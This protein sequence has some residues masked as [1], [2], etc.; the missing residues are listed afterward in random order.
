[1]KVFVFYIIV[2]L[3][4]DKIEINII[5]DVGNCLVY[6][7]RLIEVYCF[8]YEEFGCSFCLIIKY[9]DC[10]IVFLMDEVVENDLENFFKSFKREIK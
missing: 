6:S 2:D 7:S 4:L 1:M 5:I 3:R 10:K 8:D 9:K